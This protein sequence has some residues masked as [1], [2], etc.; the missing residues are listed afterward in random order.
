[1]SNTTL[2]T[3]MVRFSYLHLTKP[4][5]Q[6][7]GSKEKYSATILIPKTDT[8]TKQKIDAAIAAATQNG[9]SAKWGGTAPAVVPNP[10]HDG[11][12]IRPNGEKF[13][14]ECAGCWV[15]TANANVEHKPTVVDSNLQEIINPTE[16]YSG[17]YGRASINFFPYAFA[18]RK[19][20]GC[21]LGPVQKLRDGDP[22]GGSAVSAAE[23]FGTP[24]PGQNNANAQPKVNP[25]TGQPIDQDAPF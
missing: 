21:G 7:P 24:L 25:I 12:G 6:T 5:A 10:L 17:M 1:M 19:G 4:Y 23:A 9:I 18:G 16:I 14:P 13:G 3:G 20:I 11:D 15:L 2:T 22:L 8:E